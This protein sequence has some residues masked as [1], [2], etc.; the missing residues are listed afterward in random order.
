M[1][2]RT[3]AAWRLTAGNDQGRDKSVAAPSSGVNSKEHRFALRLATVSARQINLGEDS[4]AEL[5]KSQRRAF[6]APH[7]HNF[8]WL[9]CTIGWALV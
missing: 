6:L 4:W 8:T 1:K 3:T 7:L 5:V 2:N 9:I